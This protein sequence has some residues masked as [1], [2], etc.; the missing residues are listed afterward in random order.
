MGLGRREGTPTATPEPWLP[1]ELL[2][3]AVPVALQGV[4]R[5]TWVRRDSCD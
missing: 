5:Q 2:V 4:S 1:A 3:E